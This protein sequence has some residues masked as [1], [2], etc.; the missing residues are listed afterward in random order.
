MYAKKNLALSALAGALLCSTAVLSPVAAAGFEGKSAGDLM[1]RAR[2]VW[3]APVESSSV[4][5]IGGQATVG[6]DFIPEL[7]F[8]YFLTD[9]FAA[10]LI[11]GTSRHSVGWEGAGGAS[12]SLGKVSL[13]PPTLTFQ[14]HP[15]PKQRISPYIGAGINYTIFYDEESGDVSDISYNNTFGLAFQAGVDVAVYDNFWVNVDV[16]R[17]LLDTDA[18]I[19][20]GGTRVDADVNLDPWLIGFGIGYSF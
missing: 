5:V 4:T 1:V 11:L 12:L 3:V 18:T 2:G 9:H 16:K 20:A 6:N 15:L 7:D 14:Y 8:S 17:L 10:E 19:D 13:L